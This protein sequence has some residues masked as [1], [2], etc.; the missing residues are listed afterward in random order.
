MLRFLFLIAFMLSFT[1]VALADDQDILPDGQVLMNTANTAAPP[2]TDEYKNVK[3]GMLLPPDAKPV[4]DDDPSQQGDEVMTMDDIVAA[5]NRGEYD[6][7]VKHLQPI[8]GN[9]YPQAEELLGIMYSRGFG[10]PQNDETAISWLTKAAEAGRPLAQHYMANLTYA[11]KG[12]VKDPVTAL[13]WIYIAI[14]HYPDGPEKDRAEK[15]RAALASHLSRRDRLRAFELAH[16][17][18][19]K[20]DEDALFNRA[21]PP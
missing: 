16:E 13:M 20:R 4:T 15:D 1:G 21:P 8:A 19:Q 14:V 5:Y 3:P 9:N 18:L 10:V 2:P 11:G 6:T 12:T 17:W 7:V